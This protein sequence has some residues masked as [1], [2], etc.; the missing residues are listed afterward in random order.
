MDVFKTLGIS[1]FCSST[2]VIYSTIFMILSVKEC[3]LSNLYLKD[4]FL[5]I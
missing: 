5:K 1:V 4:E 3:P 2:P